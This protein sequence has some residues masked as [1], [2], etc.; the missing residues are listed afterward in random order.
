MGS[1]SFIDYETDLGVT[2][3][4]DDDKRIRIRLGRGGRGGRGRDETIGEKGSSRLRDQAKHV[5]S[6]TCCDLTR[7]PHKITHLH[8]PFKHAVDLDSIALKY[9]T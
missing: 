5:E 8:A 3:I 7:K 6:G 4:N 1:S 2:N 9:W